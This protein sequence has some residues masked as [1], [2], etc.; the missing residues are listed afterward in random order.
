M[1]MSRA[2]RQNQRS[3]GFAILEHL[4]TRRERFEIRCVSQCLTEYCDES[5]QN[6]RAHLSSPG[7]RAAS[8]A[9]HVG[10]WFVITNGVEVDRGQ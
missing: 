3:Y 4:N 8:I 9:K 7:C 2:V 1:I 10:A 6:P 5:D